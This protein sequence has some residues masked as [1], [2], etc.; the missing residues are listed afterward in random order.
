[1]ANYTPN[2]EVSYIS[3]IHAFLTSHSVVCAAKSYRAG[4]QL[5]DMT[6]RF[7]TNNKYNLASALKMLYNRD[8]A[9]WF[10]EKKS[11]FFPPGIQIFCNANL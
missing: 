8:I 9:F 4:D 10:S 3:L 1:M 11:T 5:L 7:R 6:L 2:V